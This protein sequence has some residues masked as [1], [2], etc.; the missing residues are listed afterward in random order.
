MK[1]CFATV[2]AWTMVELSMIRL[3]EVKDGSRKVDTRMYS[4][5]TYLL[6]VL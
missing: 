4:S 2:L 1:G 6:G 3:R 5:T